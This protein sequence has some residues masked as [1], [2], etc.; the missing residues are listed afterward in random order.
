MIKLPGLI[1]NRVTVNK[2]ARLRHPLQGQGLVEYALVLMLI[3]IVIIV[4]LVFLGPQIGNM[5]SS[6]TKSLS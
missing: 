4:I 2:K 6:V 3:V 5:F 1:K